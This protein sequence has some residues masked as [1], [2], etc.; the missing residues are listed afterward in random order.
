MPLKNIF[1]IRRDNLRKQIEANGDARRLSIVLGMNES[2]ISQLVGGKSRFTMSEKTARKY[3]K[4]LGLPENWFDNG[5]QSAA[6]IS[7]ETLPITEDKL[8]IETIKAVMDAAD[9]ANKLNL[10]G[11][12]ISSEKIGLMVALAYQRSVDKAGVDV[13]QIE[14]LIKLAASDLEK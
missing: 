3:E 7:K 10:H 8:L 13:K 1:A 9:A 11:S 6:T 2:R 5:Y 4:I 12:Q 14:M